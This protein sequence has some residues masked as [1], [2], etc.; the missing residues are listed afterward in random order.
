ME[1]PAKTDYYARGDN[2]AHKFGVELKGN[3]T[4]LYSVFWCN[5]VG[6]VINEGRQKQ[7]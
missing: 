4:L 7:I 2:K 5:Y 6:L 3:I 1:Y